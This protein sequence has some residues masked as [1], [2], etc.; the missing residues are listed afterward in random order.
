MSVGQ[1]H[2]ETPSGGDIDISVVVAAYY[3]A[4]TIADCL[5]SIHRATTGRRC[6]VIV[7]DSSGDGIVE[8]V[9]ERFPDVELI[10][11][12]ERL[13]AGGARNRGI[14]R[15]RGRFIFVTD[16]DCIVPPDWIAGLEQHFCDPAVGAVG[17]S[18]G[19]QDIA[20]LSGLAVYFLEFLRHFPMHGPP[21]R[22]ANFLVACNSAYRSEVLQSASFPEQ[23]LG[24]D[25]LLSYH[26]RCRG[27]D[28][29]YDPRVEVQ[30]QNREGWGEFFDY[31]RKMG[32][33]AA[34]YHPV[35]QYWWMQPFLRAPIFAFLAPAYILPFIAVSLIR[36]RP[37]YWPRF[38]MLWPMCLLGNLVWAA[39]FRRQV[40]C[41]RA[42][43]RA[44]RRQPSV[45]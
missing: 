11:W 9:R 28:V 17:G 10:C 37:R 31:N 36:S 16:Q 39:A 40:R 2:T 3:G 21:R 7:V 41:D 6:E 4:A 30:H 15:A 22:N 1:Q 14:E 25:V 34:R 27:I 24:E 33:A 42:R 8:I 18:V 26:V 5:Q 38:L 20:N 12:P 32:R 45:L 23:T 43:Q 35:L 29:L 13:T 19:V 44:E